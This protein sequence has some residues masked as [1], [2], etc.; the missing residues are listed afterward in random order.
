M[1]REF[2]RRTI[3]CLFLAGVVLNVRP[4]VA[5]DTPTDIVA[6][7][8]NAAADGRPW[9]QPS[10]DYRSGRSA[11]PWWTFGRTDLRSATTSSRSMPSRSTATP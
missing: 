9:P 10:R 11:S 3:G 4:A 1:R 7:G 5:S 8:E 6:H 2:T